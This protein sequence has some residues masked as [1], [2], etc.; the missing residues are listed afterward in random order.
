MPDLVALPR[1]ILEVAALKGLLRPYDDLTE[2]INGPDWYDYARQLARLQNST[3]GLP[4]AG[5]ALVLVYRSTSIAEPPKALTSTLSAQGPLAFPAAD[6]MAQFTLAQYQAV[7]GAILDEQGRPFLDR[8]A[9]TEVLAFYKQASENGSL[10][11]WLAQYQSDDQVWEAF[12][13]DQADMVVTWMS[14]HLNNLSADTAFSPIPTLNGI[15]YTLATGWVW[16]LANPNHEKQALSVELAE[17]LVESDFLARWNSETGY[18]PPRQS[19]LVNWETTSIQTMASEVV[20]S[21]RI[22]PSADVSA[23]LAPVL[24]Q[25][26]LQVLKSQSDPATASREAADKVNKP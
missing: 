23:S 21:A 3:F 26:T 4:F 20:L 15:H 10:P 12:L 1:P 11:V 2:S 18:L 8:S 17:Y 9:L 6:P 13:E 14:R 19:A 7:G 24:Q 22:Y 25:A 5:D 16:A